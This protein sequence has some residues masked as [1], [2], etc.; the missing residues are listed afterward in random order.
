[1]LVSQLEVLFK[2]VHV[3]ILLHASYFNLFA[4]GSFSLKFPV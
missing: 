3:K 4:K 1:M 2:K